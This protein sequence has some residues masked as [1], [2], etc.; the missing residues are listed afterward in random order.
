MKPIWRKQSVNQSSSTSNPTTTSTSTPA[1]SSTTTTTT[2]PDEEQPLA[3]NPNQAIKQHGEKVFDTIKMTIGALDNLDTLAQHLDEI[4]YNHYKYG[5]RLEHYNVSS[6]HYLSLSL[7]L[8]RISDFNFQIK[9]DAGWFYSKLK[10]KIIP[11]FLFKIFFYGTQKT[12]K[13][14]C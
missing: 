12:L 7:Y 5:T 14:V 11:N 9:V 6:F 4:G 10:A 8:F 2:N 1:S 13:I 3:V